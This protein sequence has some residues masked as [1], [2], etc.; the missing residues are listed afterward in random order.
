MLLAAILP[1]K[2]KYCNIFGKSIRQIIVI[3]VVQKEKFSHQRK[4]IHVFLT[5]LSVCYNQLFTIKSYA[6][7]DYHGLSW[8]VAGA[9]PYWT[10]AENIIECLSGG[11]WRSPLFVNHWSRLRQSQQTL[12]SITLDLM[13]WQCMGESKFYLIGKPND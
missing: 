3:I 6:A 13:N 8:G 4:T 12:G 9:L 5:Q 2:L 10:S 7:L 1:S 11:K